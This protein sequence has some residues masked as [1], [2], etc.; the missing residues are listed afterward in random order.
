MWLYNSSNRSVLPAAL[1]HASFN[2]TIN[3]YAGNFIPVPAEPW[4]FIASGVLAAAAILLIIFTRGRLSYKPDV[5]QIAQRREGD[6]R[7]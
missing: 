7:S 5:S 3:V 4:F 2:T 6:Q 1:F